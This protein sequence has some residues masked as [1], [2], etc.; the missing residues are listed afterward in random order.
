VIWYLTESEKSLRLD[1]ARV[2]FGYSAIIA[3]L[4]EVSMGSALTKGT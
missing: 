2:N 3:I 1:T 4:L